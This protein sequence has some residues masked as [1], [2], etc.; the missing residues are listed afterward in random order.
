MKIDKKT[1]MKIILEELEYVADVDSIFDVHDKSG[2]KFIE[3]H[4]K[5]ISIK[6]A[7]IAL[8]KNLE[9]DEKLDEIEIVFKDY[10]DLAEEVQEKFKEGTSPKIVEAVQ[11]FIENVE[12]ALD[13][14]YN[15]DKKFNQEFLNKYFTSLGQ[16][17]TLAQASFLI[18]A[19]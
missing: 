18:A 12:K 19:G 17:L 11:Q 15:K 9:P 8:N 3:K 5:E 16:P 7:Q 2:L 10:S 1:L 14:L 4:Q 13:F 6:M